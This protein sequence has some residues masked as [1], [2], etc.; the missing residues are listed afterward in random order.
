MTEKSDMTNRVIIGYAV[1]ELPIKGKHKTLI[2]RRLQIMH[3][4]CYGQGV[5]LSCRSRN[6][7]LDNGSRL[8]VAWIEKLERRY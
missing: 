6:A 3:K 4:P 1:L 8:C 2:F 7:G 5:F